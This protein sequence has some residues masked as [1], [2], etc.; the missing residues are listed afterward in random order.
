[1]P[2]IDGKLGLSRWQN[3]F[4]CEF[5][6]PRNQRRVVCTIIPVPA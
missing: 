6:G 1:M 3:I 4:L 5:N 2:I